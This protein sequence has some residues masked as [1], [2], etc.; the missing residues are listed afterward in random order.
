MR[1]RI[2]DFTVNIVRYSEDVLEKVK[3][4]EERNYPNEMGKITLEDK[5][6]NLKDKIK[7][8]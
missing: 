6:M 8:K 5:K 4:N 1:G 3:R 2:S 7:D